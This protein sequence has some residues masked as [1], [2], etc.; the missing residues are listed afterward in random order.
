MEARV[1]LTREEMRSI[2]ARLANRALRCVFVIYY[3]FFSGWSRGKCV[4]KDC[5]LLWFLN[6]T[7]DYLQFG[8]LTPTTLFDTSS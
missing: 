2:V 1:V 6:T 5:N 3:I 4:H 8:L 7:G